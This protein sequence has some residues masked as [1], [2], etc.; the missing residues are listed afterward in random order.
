M[1]F[2][3]KMTDQLLGTFCEMKKLNLISKEHTFQFMLL[4]PLDKIVQKG[5]CKDGTKKGEKSS[6]TRQKY[7]FI[8]T[9][10]ANQFEENEKY[11]QFK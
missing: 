8:S 4:M 11:W 10:F 2:S 9:R 6:G 3:L 5:F 1:G 7:K